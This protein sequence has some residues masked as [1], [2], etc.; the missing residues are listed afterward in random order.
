MR[1]DA[2]QIARMR[3]VVADQLGLELADDADDTLSAALAQRLAER[4]TSAATYL[5]TLDSTELRALGQLLT[6]GE[7]YF[8]RMRAHFDA[9]RELAAAKDRPLVV[10][11]AGCSTGEEAYSIAIALRTAGQPAS[12][13]YGVDL[14]ARSLETARRAHYSDWALRSLTAIDRDRWFTRVGKL[15]EVRPEIRANVHLR[16]GNLV[17]DDAVPLGPFDAIFCRN[18]IMYFTRDAQRIALARLT[19]ALRTGGLLFLGHAETLRGLTTEYAIEQH[20][21]AFHYRHLDRSDRA[22]LPKP[23]IKRKTPTTA[24]IEAPPPEPLAVSTPNVLALLAEEKF[25]AALAAIDPG[26]SVLRAMALLGTG[27]LD[28]AEEVCTHLVT[29]D[30]GGA[31]AH[32]VLGLAAEA[33]GDR[34]TAI[35]RHRAALYLEPDFALAHLQLGRLERREGDLTSARRDLTRALALIGTERAVTIQLFGG[36]FDRDGLRALARAELDAVS[37]AE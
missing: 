37:R 15:W 2:V 26:P 23:T 6:V 9:L 32:Y 20:G 8:F 1:V 31:E 36:G 11:S 24:W 35:D 14:N 21:D 29:L 3:E 4:R 17:D 5:A 30:Q 27:D 7:T 28:A 18:V 33:R 22:A 12:L 25:H 34:P 16:S 13:V 19:A 10:L